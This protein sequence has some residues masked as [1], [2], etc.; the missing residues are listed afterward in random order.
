V[1]ERRYQEYEMKK[2]KKKLSLTATTVRILHASL[3][4][5]LGGGGGLSG[6]CTTSH[7]ATCG[8][9]SRCA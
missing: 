2:S 6:A 3:Q 7:A 1:G 5:V 4:D 9:G 8:N